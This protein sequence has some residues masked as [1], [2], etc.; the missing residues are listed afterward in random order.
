[1]I[2]DSPFL[3]IVSKIRTAITLHLL[4]LGQHKRDD[5]FAYQIR[6]T[7]V[8]TTIVTCKF[9]D[10][11]DKIVIFPYRKFSRKIRYK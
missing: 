1:M 10:S 11:T 9:A 6:T 3:S 7:N 4:G 8:L 5:Y 2:F